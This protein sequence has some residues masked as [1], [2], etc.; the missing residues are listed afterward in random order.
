LLAAFGASLPRGESPTPQTKFELETAL[1]ASYA[2]ASARPQTIADWFPPAEFHCG[3]T[4]SGWLH[5]F[6]TM[7]WC[8]VGNVCA[9]IAVHEANCW[10]LVASPQESGSVEAL[11]FFPSV[12]ACECSG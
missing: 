3:F 7:N 10:I 12:S 1:R 4:N 6:M 2:A 5:S 9:T 8:T 11:H